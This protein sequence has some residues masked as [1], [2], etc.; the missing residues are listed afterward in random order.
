MVLPE[1][2]RSLVPDLARLTDDQFA[3]VRR[4]VQAMAVPVNARRE[5]GSDLFPDDRSLGLFFLYLVTHH[6]LSAEP[7]KKEKFEYAIERLLESLGRSVVRPSSRTNP[8]HDLTVDGNGWSFK[9]KASRDIK[10][11]TLHI[12]KWME[13]G[14]GQWVD[15]DDL[16]GLADRFLHHLM[17]YDRIFVLRCLTPDDPEN[18]HYEI[19]EVPKPLLEKCKSAG[20]FEMMHTSR[21]TPKP[22]YC[23]VS[24]ED[25]LQYELYFDGGTERK[26][27]LQKLRHSSC[28]FHAE[29]RF[30]TP[31][32]KILTGENP[33]AGE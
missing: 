26:L 8:G 5:P 3:W 33:S 15:E 32:P 23:R 10:P 25:G 2:V 28:R 7:F 31:T 12:S 6:T 14:K 29:W 17:G 22:G 18:H 27:R 24:D 16:R 21:Q 4:L 19:V 11:N 20:V 1:E 13:L 9:S 30:S